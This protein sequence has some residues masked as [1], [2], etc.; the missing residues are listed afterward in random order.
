MRIEFSPGDATLL[1]RG[2]LRDRVTPVQGTLTYASHLT[3]HTSE[4]KQSHANDRVNDMDCF[5]TTRFAMT[6]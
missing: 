6:T 5:V 4:A 3:R 2:V 1:R